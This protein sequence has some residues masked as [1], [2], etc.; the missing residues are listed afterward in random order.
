MPRKIKVELPDGQGTVLTEIAADNELQLQ[1]LIKDTPDLLP[2]EEF[3]EDHSY[4]VIGRE[5]Y[6]PSGAVDLIGLTRGGDLLIIELKT[7]PQNSDFRRVLAQLLDYGSD[8]WRMSLE[9]FESTVARR[10][11]LHNSCTDERVKG[12]I[13]LAEAMKKVWPDITELETEASLQK[14]TTN[15]ENGKFEYVIVA[16]RFSEPTLRTLDYLNESMN[17]SKFFAVELVKFSSEE[18]SAYESRTIAKPS[19]PPTNGPIITEVEALHKIND[20][21]Y[22]RAVGNIFEVCG[23]WNI[24]RAWGA[25]G[26]SMRIL[27]NE[28]KRITMGWWFPPAGS[29][30]PPTWMGLR[31]FTLGYDPGSVG[32]DNFLKSRLDKYVDKVSRIP[33]AQRETKAGLY[34]YHFDPRALVQAESRITE[35]FEELLK[36]NDENHD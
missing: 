5:T 27:T 4:F 25:A 6:L 9:D 29:N 10:Y 18:I 21:D 7:G 2:T 16:Q 20:E 14:L 23:K 24:Q 8:L 15:L 26:T 36:A 11:F 13:A 34:A 35:L 31:D 1:D 17:G 3:G 32:E 22:R 28:G 33:G 19:R 12:I 30:S